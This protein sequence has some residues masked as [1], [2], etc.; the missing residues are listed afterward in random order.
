MTNTKLLNKVIDESGYKRTFI[1][2]CL[3][4]STFSLSKKINNI[5]EFKASEIEKLSKL[6]ELTPQQ[7][8]AI[9]FANSVD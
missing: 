9:F 7:K 3:G 6:L 8:E 5:T 2:N 4:I 1:A